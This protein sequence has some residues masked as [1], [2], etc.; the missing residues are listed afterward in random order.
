MNNSPIGKLM[1]EGVSEHLDFVFGKW[2]YVIEHF[3]NEEFGTMI[4][5]FDDY[6]ETV[7]SCKIL[8]QLITEDELKEMVIK[9]TI[10]WILEDSEKFKKY[11][12]DENDIKWH[13]MFANILNKKKKVEHGYPECCE[14]Y[15]KCPICGGE[16]TDWDVDPE[17]AED[18]FNSRHGWNGDDY[19]WNS[20]DEIHRC[21]HCEKLFYIEGES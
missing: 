17:N 9:D 16:L 12:I 20:W 2:R 6:W 10:S 19:E 21:P 1:C 11:F 14:P 15:D 3:N 4:Y 5:R 8:N 13:Y 18:I 7:F